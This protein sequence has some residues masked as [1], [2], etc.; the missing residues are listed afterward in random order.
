MAGCFAVSLGESGTIVAHDSLTAAW[1]PC[2]SARVKTEHGF[3]RKTVGQE[4]AEMIL[5]ILDREFTPISDVR[6]SATYRQ[7]L[8]KTLLRKFFTE[9]MG[10]F[11]EPAKIR[12]P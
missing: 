6:G 4:T 10:C 7:Q 1:P 2:R 9:E 5:P 3:D 11:D 12:A 8:I